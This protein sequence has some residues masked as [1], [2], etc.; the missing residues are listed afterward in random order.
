MPRTS[1]GC[2]RCRQRRV[3]CDETRPTCRRCIGRNEVCV[4]YREEADLIFRHQT[5]Q[6]VAKATTAQAKQISGP[7]EPRPSEPE[8]LSSGSRTLVRSVSLDSLSLDSAITTSTIPKL[9]EQPA[10]QQLSVGSDESLQVQDQAVCKFFEKYIMY[11]GESSKSG[12]LEHLPCLFAEVNVEGRYALRW[13][14][15]AAALADGSREYSTGAGLAQ[16][17][18]DCY[19]KAL[20]ALRQSLSEKG[21]V[22]DDYDLM[23]IVILDFFE[24]LFLPDARRG[25]HVQ[26]IAHVLRLRGTQFNDP[27]GWSLFRLA[28]HQMQKQRLAFRLAPMKESEPLLD[29]LSADMDYLH[30]EKDVLQIS[31]VCER[32]RKLVEDLTDTDMSVRQVVDIVHEMQ[33][34]DQAAVSWRQGA[35]WAFTTLLKAELTGSRLVAADFP[36]P[37]QIHPDIWSAYEWNYHRAARITLHEQLLTCL[38]RASTAS[39][40]LEQ[41]DAA[42]V[43]PLVVESTTIIRSLADKVLATVPQSLGDLDN[44]GRVRDST[45]SPPKCRAV[46]A[47]LLLWPIKVIKAAQSSAS[48]EQKLAAQS[49][50]ERIREYTGARLYLGDLSNI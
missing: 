26:G 5:A 6:V 13:A 3:R 38:R 34:L 48:E 46:G 21:K 23:T 39:A 14:V 4:G 44:S 9:G 7:E 11:P 31:T 8:S 22:P 18:L 16:Q 50:F 12:F 1:R 40:H 47:Y 30:L 15:Q 37:V 25:A 29:R 41:N 2:L 24:A 43:A 33:A 49:V 42:V 36:D 19:G 28:H 27:R 20:A 45:S 17:A 35:Q 32:A 10:H